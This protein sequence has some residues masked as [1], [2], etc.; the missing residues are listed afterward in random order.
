MLPMTIE[1]VIVPVLE[2]RVASIVTPLPTFAKLRPRVLLPAAA[3]MPT[4]PVTVES[5]ITPATLEPVTARLLLPTVPLAAI[6][7]LPPILP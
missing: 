3:V 2:P 5:V 4:L 1:S 6:A 7:T